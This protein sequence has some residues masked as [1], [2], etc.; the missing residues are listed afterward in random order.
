MIK[1]KEK[2]KNSGLAPTPR[3]VQGLAPTPRK[4]QGFTLLEVMVSVFIIAIALTGILALV[5]YTIGASQLASLRLTAA[6][7]AQEGIEIVKSIR[8]SNFDES[9]W[10]NWYA[11]FLAN[12]G[13]KCYQVQYLT[14]NLGSGNDIPNCL[15]SD[16]DILKYDATSG[17]YKYG[18]G[19]NT[20]NLKR[21][22]TL[23]KISDNEIKVTADVVWANRGQSYSLSVEDRLWNWR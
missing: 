1:A 10:G 19:V 3:K 11:S 16:T 18:S 13:P 7:L 20:Y 8:E 4:V 14:P 2:Q 17:L 23:T 15:I 6:N 22:I 21:M 5:S 12:S 9:G